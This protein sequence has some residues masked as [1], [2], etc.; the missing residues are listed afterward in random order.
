[1]LR[2]TKESKWRKIWIKEHWTLGLDTHTLQCA[3]IF[4][5]NLSNKRSKKLYC[6]ST[7]QLVSRLKIIDTKN[8]WLRSVSSILYSSIPV[9]SKGGSFRYRRDL[10]SKWLEVV[11]G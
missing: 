7:K 5:D 9:R 4:Q 1:M 10:L 6:L 11:W 3:L 8:T 2:G